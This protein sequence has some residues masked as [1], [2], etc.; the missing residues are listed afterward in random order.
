MNELIEQLTG[1]LGIDKGTAEK[2]VQSIFKSIQDNLGGEAFTK[3][4]GTLPGMD[5]LLKQATSASGSGAGEGGLLGK[6]AGMA[7]GLLGEGAGSGIELGAALKSAGL[8]AD[9]LPGLIQMVVDFI[10]KNA[11]PEVVD[12]LLEKLPMLK[13]LLPTGSK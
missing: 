9:K 3:L 8:S 4:S 10:R 12:Q 1:Q 6:L 5:D 7:S 11:G 2:S 13:G